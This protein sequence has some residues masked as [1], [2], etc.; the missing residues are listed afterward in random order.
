MTRP[1]PAQL[2]RRRAARAARAFTLIE[3]ITVVAIIAVIMAI[4]LPMLSSSMRNARKMRAASDLQTIRMGLDAYRTDFGDYPR[5]DQNY[6]GFALLTKALIAPGP[7]GGPLPPLGTAPFP[8]GTI[9]HTGTPGQAGY[10]EFVAFGEPTGDG[11]TAPSGPPDNTKWAVFFASDGKDG[12]GF[13]VRVGGGQTSGP[14]L[15]EGKFRLRGLAMLDQWDNP[16][17]YFPARPQKPAPDASGEWPIALPVATSLYN[18]FH[19]LTFFMRPGDND[20]VKAR[21]RMEAVLVPNTTD[22]DGMVGSTEQAATTNAFLLWS[23]GAD[24]NF[25]AT[26]AGADPTAD[27]IKKVDDVTNFTTGQ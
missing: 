11:F 14:Y 1:H 9:A 7:A 24:G 25:G 8:A 18:P 6:V 15:Q 2:H 10:L 22:W 27:E 4:A 23:A 13:R 20:Q 26:F 3:V 17:L 12:P 19:N 16:I 21:K 5:P